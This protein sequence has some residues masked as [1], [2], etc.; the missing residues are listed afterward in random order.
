ME[1]NISVTSFLATEKPITATPP[2][3]SGVASA[4]THYV[5]TLFSTVTPGFFCLANFRWLFFSLFVKWQGMH[6]QELRQYLL[7]NSFSYTASSHTN[8]SNHI[9]RRTGE[10][11][12]TFCML[13]Q[14]CSVDSGAHK[15]WQ[16]HVLMLHF[17]CLNE[18]CVDTGYVH[19][20]LGIFAY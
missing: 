9:C 1:Q 13:Q 19:A 15:L 2:S 8:R 16:P 4:T 20:Q 18:I 5:G 7:L 10:I 17:L 14:L 11:V 6:F 3:C 12:S